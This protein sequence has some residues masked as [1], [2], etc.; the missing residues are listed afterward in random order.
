MERGRRRTKSIEQEPGP[1]DESPSK[2]LLLLNSV[3]IL[4]LP[5]SLILLATPR[6]R[7]L[8][9]VDSR[10]PAST[11]EGEEATDHPQQQLPQ[12]QTASPSDQ[13]RDRK[14]SFKTKLTSKLSGF[15]ARVKEEPGREEKPSS[16][17]ATSTP[18]SKW[19]KPLLQ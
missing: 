15:L 18:P 1:G 17:A 6:R 3:I 11:G 2:Y 4:S 12:R 14:G 16:A 8:A 7:D 13:D 5:L 10:V 19:R 9:E